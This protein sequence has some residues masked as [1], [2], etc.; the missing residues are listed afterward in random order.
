M[1]TQSDYHYRSFWAC[2][3][4]PSS[5]WGA[6]VMLD[7][8]ADDGTGAVLDAGIDPGGNAWVVWER[9]KEDRAVFAAHFTAPLVESVAS[10]Q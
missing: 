2:L 10:L 9:Q 8:G 3:Y 7:D 6:P 1:W 4:D 5:G